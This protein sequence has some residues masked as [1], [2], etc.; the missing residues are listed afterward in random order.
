M[1]SHRARRT[2]ILIP[3]DLVREIDSLVGSRG[4]SGFLVNSAREAVRRRR[5][6]QFLD[7]KEPA[8]NGAGHPD[9][10]AGAAPWVRKLRSQSEKRNRKTRRRATR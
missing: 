9:L 3:E 8:W 2:H 6:L 7:S 4:R 5:L 1:K 10:A